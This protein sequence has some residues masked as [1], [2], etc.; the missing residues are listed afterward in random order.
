MQKMKTDHI[1]PCL[2]M[3]IYDILE[4]RH[5][6]LHYSHAY[7]LCEHQTRVFAWF[8]IQK[9]EGCLTIKHKTKHVLYTY[10]MK[11]CEGVVL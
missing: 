6:L 5:N 7:H 9:I 4:T 11:D 10:F 8:I 3:T 2:G 1:N